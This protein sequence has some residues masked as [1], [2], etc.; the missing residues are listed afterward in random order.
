MLKEL[1]SRNVRKIQDKI[2]DFSMKTLPP[3]EWA[4]K[5]LILSSE[6]KFSG[7]FSYNRSPYT[8]E[9]VDNMRPN[10]GVEITAVMKCSQSGFTQSVAIPCMVYHVAESPTNVMFLSSSDTMV[11][12]T[13]R[14]RFDTVMESSGLS[15]LLK[16]SSVKKA[17]QRTGDTDKKKEYTGG[18]MINA[19]Y[20]ASNLRFHSVEVV[21]A[22]EYDD[23]PKTDKKEGSIFDLIKARTKSYA[24]TRRLVFMSSP[25]VK[26][27]SNI[28]HVYNMGDKRHWNWECPHCK[29]YIPILWRVEKEDGT[30]GGIKW[31]LDGNDKLIED[32]VHYEC[33]KCCGRIEYKSKYSLNLTGKW[34]PTA[35]PE[36]PSY[37]SYLFNALCNPPG[38]ESWTDLVRQWMKA[39]PKNEPIDI[40]ALKVFTNTQLGELWEDRGTTPR[41]TGLMNNVGTYKVGRVP[42][43]TCEED[44]NG[45]IALISL[46][47]DLGGIMDMVNGIEDVRLDWEILAHTSNGQTYSI[48]HGS[49]G[50]FKRSRW[51]DQKDRANESNRQQWTFNHGLPNSVWNEFKEIIYTPLQGEGEDGLY[52]DIDITL[53]DTGHFT[54]LA[55]NFITS[56][57]DRKIFGIKGDTVEKPRLTDKNSPIIKHSQ[58]NKGLLYIL[59]VNLLKDQ[60]AANMNLV[61]GTDGTQPSGFMNFPQPSKGK[62]NLKSFFS[63]YESEHRVPKIVNGQ[64][65]GFMWKKKRED[66][67]FWDIYNYNMAAREIFIADLKRQD[68][69]NRDLSWISFCDMINY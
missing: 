58:E 52:Y 64:E 67:H 20:N 50:T 63:H 26:G 10:S 35:V 22:D 18:T 1:I 28:E 36:H 48:N 57:K 9:V 43:K 49:I 14:G 45:K 11:Q 16:T 68:S 61:C 65:V 59:D 44:G 51:R 33:Q 32:S 39:C 2:Y 8:R 42:D 4:E 31:E 6:S 25:T 24:D 47:A 62:Y 30:Y 69:K 54:K 5:N 3:S 21:V 19:T 15:N 29:E 37:R 12:N 56:I 27:I 23:A 41:A 55:Y 17:N 40:D 13:I 66:N 38:F 60:A 34:I 7:M 53:V 46:S